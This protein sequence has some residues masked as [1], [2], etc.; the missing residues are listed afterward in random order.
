MKKMIVILLIIALMI[1]TFT[2]G[3]AASS[4]SSGLQTVWN[5]SGY[6]E[7][8][9]MDSLE[10]DEEAYISARNGQ[11]NRLIHAS[12]NDKGEWK[13][14]WSNESALPQRASDPEMPGVEF[15]K[16]ID[17]SN[18][19]YAGLKL[20]TAFSY[21][22]QRN[23][24]YEY[25]FQKHGNTWLLEA[26]VYIDTD[27]TLLDNYR[28]TEDGVTYK[29]W[30]T[31]DRKTFI[32]GRVQRDLRYFSCSSFPTDLNALKNSLSNPPEIPVG[33][34]SA[35]EIKFTGGKKYSVYSG[36]GENYMRSGNGKAAVSTNDWIQVFGKENS[37]I[38]IQ[39]DITSD[40]MRIGWI[41]D[42]ALPKKANVSVLQFNNTSAWTTKVV[43]V[44][45][46]PLYSQSSLISL[47]EGC[48]VTWLAS[49]GDWAYIE[50][51]T[52]DY[53]RGFVPVNSLR[54]N[55]EF[56]LRNVPM[57]D[58]ALLEGTLSIDS[59]GRTV[60]VHFRPVSGGPL[61]GKQIGSFDL[62]DPIH[63]IV[64]ASLTETDQAGFYS[65]SFTI[66]ADTTMIQITALPEYGFMD[67][68][69]DE[70][71]ISVEW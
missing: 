42:D 13:I 54:I 59:S 29:G 36:P 7:W 25:V 58:T 17:R 28:I 57:G 38:M 23:G 50:S 46:D 19:S 52:G 49:M 20:K 31:N 48:L 51:T 26:I 62:T 69:G 66:S 10:F 4:L 56:D 30:L 15:V 18:S 27:G 60:T 68:W 21:R 40:H 45:D 24:C 70:K 37:W 39:Y 12:K 5:S 1:S 22:P 6:Q 34:L 11:T 35:E 2:S 47:P 3:I 9:I 64:L 14:G 44:T 61:E 55:Q 32:E 53:L 43:N 67:S 33:T 41:Q 65:A 71:S 8:E 16:L 63:Q